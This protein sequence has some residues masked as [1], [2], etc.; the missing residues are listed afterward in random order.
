MSQTV[1]VTIV[2]DGCGGDCSPYRTSSPHEYVVELSLQDIARYDGISAIYDVAI[3]P[4][5]DGKKHFCDLECL[6]AWVEAQPVG[7]RSW[8]FR[9]RQQ[10]AGGK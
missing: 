6:R 1:V 2:C 5:L 9:K 3:G 8:T 7:R 4:P 10:S